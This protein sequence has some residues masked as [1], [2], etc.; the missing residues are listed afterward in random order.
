ME[1][2][3]IEDVAE[4]TLVE[5]AEARRVIQAVEALYQQLVH[6]WIYHRERTLFLERLPSG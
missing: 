6:T 1:V 2:L 4:A 3:E 5:A